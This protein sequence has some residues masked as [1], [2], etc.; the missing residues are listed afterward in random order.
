MTRMRT[1]SEYSSEARELA[2]DLDKFDRRV[3]QLGQRGQK[4]VGLP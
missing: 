2:S 3:I 4:A 1:R